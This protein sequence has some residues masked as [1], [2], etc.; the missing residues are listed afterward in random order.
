MHHF[1]MNVKTQSMVV[2]SAC[3]MVVDFHH[4]QRQSLVRERLGHG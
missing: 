2:I 1:L 4:K 3:F